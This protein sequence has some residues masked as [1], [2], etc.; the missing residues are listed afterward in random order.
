MVDWAGLSLYSVPFENGDVRQLRL[1]AHP[2]D[3]VRAF[4]DRYAPAHPIQLSEYAASH[5]SGAAP[6]QDYSAFAAQQLR[7]VY[8]GAWLTMPRLKNINWLDLDMLAGANGGKVRQRRNDYRLFASPAK[9]NAFGALRSQ[10]AF[11]TSW[12]AVAAAGRAGVPTPGRHRFSR[13]S[14]PAE[15]CGCSWPSLRARFGCAWTD[16]RFRWRPHCRTAS[17]WRRGSS[18]PARTAWRFRCWGLPGRCCSRIPGRLRPSRLAERTHTAAFQGFGSAFQGGIGAAPQAQLCRRTVL[19]QA[20]VPE[21]QHAVRA[22]ARLRRCVTISE[23]CPCI[24]RSR[25]ATT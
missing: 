3:L 12:S 16:D 23:V 2:L 4:Y 5:R 21:H 19:D 13:A 8:W 15:P 18:P 17:R 22:R 11:M 9:R 7:E 25:A 14:G 10:D 20:A 24:S 6:G 1:N